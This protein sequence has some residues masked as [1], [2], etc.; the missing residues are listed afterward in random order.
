MSSIIFMAMQQKTSAAAAAKASKATTKTRL[1]RAAE[2]LF[3]ENGLGAVS[4]RDITRAAGAK[5]ESALHYHFGSK[6]AL[7]RAVFADRI[8]DIDSK[9]L[10]LMEEMDAA[11]EGNDMV[12]VMETTI[13][14]MLETCM[15]EG[16][17][18]YAMFLMQIAADPRFE[19]DRLME[20]LA[21]D[22]VQAS[23]RR[24]LNLL[25]D[26]PRDS[27]RMR[28]RLLPSFIIAAMA[29]FAREVEAGT[30]PDLDWAIAEAGRS[31][32]AYLTGPTP[33]G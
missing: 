19:V 20:D 30:A 4:V 13:A 23:S 17:R 22:G 11:G 2:R 26:V 6:E 25:E 21:P 7:I 3:A 33:K 31:L 9:R 15:E 29:D 10:A 27:V 1:I 5:N 14:P 16:G 28:M 12:R 8:K 32:A 18:L 24:M